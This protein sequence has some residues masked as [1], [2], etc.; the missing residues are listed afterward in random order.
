MASINILFLFLAL[1]GQPVVAVTPGME[2]SSPSFM[3]PTPMGRT[4]IASYHL[5][6]PVAEM[7]AGLSLP[8]NKGSDTRSLLQT[9]RFDTHGNIT[10]LICYEPAVEQ[11]VSEK[12]LS[13]SFVNQYDDRERLK[14]FTLTSTE[15][16]MTNRKVKIEAQRIFDDQGRLSQVKATFTDL[17][18]TQNIPATLSTS[19]DFDTQGR[20]A[21]SNVTGEDDKVERDLFAATYSYKTGNITV[22]S[23]KLAMLHGANKQQQFN[24]D[25][26]LTELHQLNAKEEITS[27]TF[28]EYNA[29]GDLLRASSFFAGNWTRVTFTDYVYDKYHNW[30]ERTRHISLEHKDGKDKA[31]QYRTITYH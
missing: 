17:T 14:Q 12:V 29:Q 25:G 31:K 30:V 4:S 6:G 28:F 15:A 5:Q 1:I 2:Q 10:E 20:L 3:L 19:T 7:Q 16:Q 9:I 13:W 22:V 24:A 21:K 26:L 11:S 18:D 8:Q 23:S 27:K